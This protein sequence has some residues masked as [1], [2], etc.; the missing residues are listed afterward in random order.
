[1]LG[2]CC[3]VYN[4][5]LKRRAADLLHCKQSHATGR[6]AALTGVRPREDIDQQVMTE[7]GEVIQSHR[8]T[9]ESQASKILNP[10]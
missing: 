7:R 3:A 8:N 6:G 2:E 9:L 10:P 4:L 1:M 5:S